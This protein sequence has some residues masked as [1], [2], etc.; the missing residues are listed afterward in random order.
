MKYP[1]IRNLREDRDLRQLDIANYLGVKQTAY[2]KYE[3]GRRNMTPE[4]LIR[5]AKFHNTSID[6]LLG[7][8]DN[9]E[10]YV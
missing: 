3:L 4:V 6:Y 2:S 5:L 9:K 7:C 10:P 8:T 1:R